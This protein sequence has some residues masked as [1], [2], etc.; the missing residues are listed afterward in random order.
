MANM[1]I[2]TTCQRMYFRIGSRIHP[3]DDQLLCAWG[4]MLEQ[5]RSSKR[6]CETPNLCCQIESD[7]AQSATQVEMSPKHRHNQ[8]I[9]QRTCKHQHKSCSQAP[10]DETFQR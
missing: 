1:C 3:T 9:S 2:T 5:T 8:N 7:A 6:R 10:A 4:L